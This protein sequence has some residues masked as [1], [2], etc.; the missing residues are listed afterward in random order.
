[1]LDKRRIRTIKEGEPGPGPVVYWMSRDQR[2][3]DNWGL[4]FAQEQARTRQQPLVVLFCL[5]TGFL[6]A[7][8]RQY[9]FMLRGLEETAVG[10]ADRGIGFHLLQGE[11]A[12]VMPSFLRDLGASIL[13]TDF[14]PLGIK[15]RWLNDV[16]ER[17]PIPVVQVDS[18]NIVPSWLAS[19]KAE[20]GAYTLRPKLRRLLPEFLT[21]FPP[22]LAQPV[23]WRDQPPLPVW[24][25]VLDNL[26]VDRQVPEVS[27]LSGADSA[28]SAMDRFIGERLGRY[29]LQANDPTRKVQSGLSPYLHFGQLSAQRLALEAARRGPIPAATDAFLEQ[30]IVRRELA[31]NFCYH[32]P[33]YTTIDAFPAWARRTLEEHRF[34]AREH[35]YSLAELAAG[36]THDP[37]WNAAQHELITAGTMHGYLR[38]YWAKKILEWSASPE[39]ALAAAIFLND[40]Y[41]LDGRDPNGYTGIAWSIG[42]VHDR[43]WRERPIFGTI[44]YMSAAGCARKFPVERYL[45]RVDALPAASA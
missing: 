6:G 23:P 25:E 30:L 11:P 42:G 24:K 10:V 33:D 27:L 14:D 20:W 35:V 7:T 21:D 26:V 40:R 41:Q 31:D 22:L 19:D 36:T 8:I 1:M 28:H 3:A 15:R 37:L 44:R 12:Q 18:H 34:D 17:I 9:G 5:K 45:E 4:L 32:H 38:M 43:P 29:H 39:D 2:L 13:V 16:A